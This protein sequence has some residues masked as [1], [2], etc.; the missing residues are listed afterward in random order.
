MATLG[1]SPGPQPRI[2]R[3]LDNS[4]RGSDVAND[5]RH[6]DPAQILE[7]IAPQGDSQGGIRADDRKRRKLGRERVSAAS[8]RLWAEDTGRTLNPKPFIALIGEQNPQ[9][10]EHVV[11]FDPATARV[12][13]LTKP[14][15]FGAQGED[16]GAYFATLPRRYT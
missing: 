10:G 6:R 13:K 16:A 9:G 8:L 7:T 15:F 14:G 12:V 2:I 1:S 5:E 3:S 11:M 4:Y